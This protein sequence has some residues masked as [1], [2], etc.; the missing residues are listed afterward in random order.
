MSKY[1][2]LLAIS[3]LPSRHGIGDF[4]TKAYRFIDWLEESGYS[5]WQFLP[6]NPVGPGNSPYM[7]VCSEA[8]EPR[9][10]SLDFLTREN[11][12]P[13]VPTFRSRSQ[14]VDYQKVE[15]F[16]EFYLFKAFKKYFKTKN[17][18]AFHYFQN[19]N[20][21][22]KKYAIFLCLRRK[23]NLV[24]WNQ[25]NEEDKHWSVEQGY[26]KG[27]E[28]EC[29]FYEWTQ[30]IA[31]KQ[32]NKLWAYAK[33]HHISI[34]ADCPFYVGIDSADCFFNK[35]DFL[36]DE[37]Y[38]PTYVSGCPPDAFSDDGQLWGTPIYNFWDLDKKNYDLL[39]NRIGYLANTC[40]YLRLDHFRAF[41]TYC[42]IPGKDE[43]ARRGE[44]WEGPRYRFFDELYRKYPNI[45]LIAED[46]GDL[47]QGVHDLRDHY[48]LP[49]MYITEFTVFDVKQFPKETQIIY[50]GTH[51]NQTIQGWLDTLPEENIRFLRKKFGDDADL[52]QSF[53]DYTWNLPS[54]LTIFS[55]QDLMHLDD[56]ARMNYPGT[57]GSPNWEW[58][59]RDMHF[60]KFAKRVH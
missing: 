16:K 10:I 6:L 13:R 50:P 4:G 24:S 57:T 58:K 32:W 55:L 20:P 53:F 56:K 31:Y 40:D 22:T 39:V 43:N 19:C 21:W 47:F 41:D 15:E 59:L 38:E 42:V 60:M 44:W 25:W 12:L 5:Y 37:H 27:H 54:Y 26:P 45:H 7:S 36:F 2:V 51:D 35:E 11:L 1:G 9:Y 18:R 8:I 17:L 46:L 34:I 14:K 30:F 52:W 33:A 29:L 48:K 28:E 49:G 3:S 23:N